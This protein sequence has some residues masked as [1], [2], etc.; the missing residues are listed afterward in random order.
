MYSHKRN[1]TN[2]LPCPQEGQFRA[3]ELC[4]VEGRVLLAFTVSMVIRELLQGT[5]QSAQQRLAFYQQDFEVSTSTPLTPPLFVLHMS[6][7]PSFNYCV[8]FHCRN[9]LN[10]SRLVLIDFLG[11]VQI[12]VGLEKAAKNILC[13]LLRD[14][15]FHFPRSGI[16]SF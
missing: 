12:L 10:F 15:C 8:L 4:G 7:V 13:G 11:S 1:L 6:I 16:P 5:G 9:T 2:Y 3:L 14:L